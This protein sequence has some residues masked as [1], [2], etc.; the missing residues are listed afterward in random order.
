MQAKS[1]IKDLQKKI[2]E[3]TKNRDWEQFHNH[4]DMAISII[5]EASELLEHF[6][7]KNLK[8]SEMHAKTHKEEIQDEI[9][10][11]F[12][13]VLELSDNLNINLPEAVVKKL[14]KNLK[15]Y[16]VKKA[17]GKNIKYNK[18]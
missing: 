4:K 8:E 12:I 2:R 18:L 16:P 9:A 6:Q 14:K 10:D 13:Y 11:I 5:L 17:K 7:W 15:K 1:E 3:F